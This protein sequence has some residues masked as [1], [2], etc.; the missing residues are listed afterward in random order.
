[1]AEHEISIRQASVQ[2]A[3]VIFG[4]IV[5]LAEST[6][7]A[8]RVSS[9]ADDITEALSGENPEVH[10][11]IAE[12]D[13]SPVGVA[14]FFLTYS[15][16]RGTRGV[17]LQ[18]IYLASTVRGTGL[19][20][21]LMRETVRW[22]KRLGAD[23]LRLAVDRD[24]SDAQEFYASIGLRFRDDEKIYQIDDDAFDAMGKST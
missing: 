21:R 23:H 14:V 22:S 13:G 20:T 18:D 16:W 9:T 6:D 8:A 19:G 3:P 10:A 5:E 1:M 24:N 7:A 4:M 12:S 11:L 2:D 17:Y 15:T